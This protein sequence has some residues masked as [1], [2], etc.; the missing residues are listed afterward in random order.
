MRTSAH[1]IHIVCALVLISCANTAAVQPTPTIAVATHT[2]TRAVAADMVAEIRTYQ[3]R[4]NDANITHYRFQLMVGCFC[5][6]N[7]VMPITIEVDNDGVTSITDARGVPVA[8]DDAGSGFF[9]KYTTIDGIYDALT[10]AQFRD[11]ETLTVTYDAT[12]PVPATVSADFIEM[13][14]DDEVYVEV[15]GFTPQE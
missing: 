10:S 4:W 12:Y 3:T 8:P 6:M 14:V 7:A 15:S 1:F 9:R 13:A 5:P 11:A 2:P